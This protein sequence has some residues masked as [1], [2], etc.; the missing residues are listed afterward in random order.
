VGD[1]S[2][3]IETMK[4]V[5][6]YS[7]TNREGGSSLQLQNEALKDLVR[8]F[9]DA[10]EMTEA[11]EYFTKLGKKDLI[12]SMLKRL[13]YLY[14]EQGKF[15]QAIETYR[16]LILEDPQ[17]AKCPGYQHEIIQAY[18]KVGQKERTLEEIDRLR[19][20]Y[21]KSSAWARANSSNQ[22]ELREAQRRIEENLRR[23]AVEFHNQ[24]RTL[25]KSRHPESGK[26]Y[27]L[28]DRAYATYLEEFPEGE[29]VY[30]VRYAYGEL[31]YKLKRFDEAYV[32]YVKV[33]EIDAKGKHSRFCAEAAIFASDEMV[34]REGGNKSVPQ[35]GEAKDPQPLTEWEQKLVDSS[36]LYASLYPDDHKKVRSIIYKSAYLLYNKYRF[37]EAADQFKK[38]IQMDPKSKQA[39]Q[40]A[41]LILD[42][43]V[44]NQDYKNLKKNAKFYYDQEGL[45]SSKFKTEVYNIYQRASFKLI[46]ITHEK[47]QDFSV[48]ADSF[49]AYYEEFPEA[50]TAAQALNNASV[51]YYKVNRIADAMK[52]R[53]ILIEDPKFGAA[54]KYYYSQIASLGYDYET[55]A[56]FEKAAY[57]YEKLHALWPEERKKV[58]K[59]APDT[60]GE[61]DTQA[62]DAI[63]SAAVFRNALGKW[64]PAI[65]NYG[66]FIKDFGSDERVI[67]VRLTIGRT[68]EDHDNWVSSANVFYQFYTKHA[69]D[70]D[71]SFTY[72]ARLHY[73]RALENQNQRSK[74]LRVYEETANLYRKYVE[75]GGEKGVHTEFVAEMMFK[76]AQAKYEDYLTLK[77]TGAPKGSSKRSEDK[78]LAASLKK[79]NQSLLEIEQLY[80]EIIGTGAGE[81]G[82]ASLVRLGEAY[83]NMGQTLDKGH[84]PFYLTEEQIELYLMKIEDKVYGQEEKAVQAYKLALDKSYELTLYNANTA[85]AT[86]R[87]G[88]MRPDEFQGLEEQ[89]L[90]PNFTSTSTREFNFEIEL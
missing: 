5:V 64:E 89:L 15:D 24:A 36:A 19:R 75:K 48:T 78:A 60:I 58:E 13:A 45:G 38:V 90:E 12:Q 86:R 51:Y 83:E 46:E 23:V 80:T 79:K 18:R 26:V 59:D 72:F 55:I 50:D 67:D 43:F 34:N 28:A 9:A 47:D 53:H 16:R 14:F 4:A 57:Y 84:I 69:K 44:V 10:G 63:Y 7:M 49:V 11:Y 52:V 32:Q 1:F 70:A 62:A 35:P 25:E 42:S 39:E 87:L 88:E 71:A 33:V 27:S 73:G 29:H 31:L 81:W 40:A 2:K 74:A 3:G 56:H 20:D 30:E 41:N 85:L 65:A 21:G 17:S 77:L 54:T 37:E 8:F 82:L 66:K 68:Y 76:L 61:F 22:D 6:S